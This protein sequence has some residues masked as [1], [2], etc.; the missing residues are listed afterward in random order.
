MASH[1]TRR[2]LFS[3]LRKRVPVEH[4]SAGKRGTDDLLLTRP[5]EIHFCGVPVAADAAR[6]HC[7]KLTKIDFFF[8]RISFVQELFGLNTTCISSVLSL[9]LFSRAPHT[10]TFTDTHLH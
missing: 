2:T 7:I 4:A 3:N 5:S 1:H 10:R 9:S 8:L 6:R